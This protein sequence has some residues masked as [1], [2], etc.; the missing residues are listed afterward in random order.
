M[1]LRSVL[2]AALGFV[3]SCEALVIAQTAQRT[4]LDGVYTDAQAIRGQR[5]YFEYCASCHGWS[6]EGRNGPRPG[7]DSN[8]K[9]LR[10]PVSSSARTGM[11]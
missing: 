2:V 5:L 6:L 8:P 9:S 11:T 10:W 4:I 3:A 7:E 1:H